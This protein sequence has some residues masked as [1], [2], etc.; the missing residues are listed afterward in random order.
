MNE[1][2]FTVDLHGDIYP[3]VPRLGIIRALSFLNFYTFLCLETFLHM[4]QSKDDLVQP[5]PSFVDQNDKQL[6]PLEL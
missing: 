3:N 5:V 2:T 1:F 4:M 6:S